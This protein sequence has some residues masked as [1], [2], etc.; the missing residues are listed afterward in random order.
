MNVTWAPN[1][2]VDDL[3][4]PLQMMGGYDVFAVCPTRHRSGPALCETG[5]PDGAGYVLVASVDDWCGGMD[6]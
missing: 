6:G 1:A 4:N 2:C 3:T 5:V